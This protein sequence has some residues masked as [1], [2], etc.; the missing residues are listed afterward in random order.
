MHAKATLSDHLIVSA[1]DVH[2]QAQSVNHSIQYFHSTFKA[3]T[4]DTED[5]KHANAENK[6]AYPAGRSVLKKLS[7]AVLRRSQT[8]FSPQEESRP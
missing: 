4:E 1:G 8:R 5:A 3:E 2:C 6:P 7:L